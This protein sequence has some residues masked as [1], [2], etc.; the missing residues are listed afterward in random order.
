MSNFY[1]LFK[2]VEDSRLVRTANGALGF[3]T[4]GKA[5]LDMNFGVSSY[6]SKSEDVILKDF[7]RAYSENPEL[8]LKWAFYVG[9]V[10]EGL[11]ERRLFRCLIKL[12]CG[13]GN[14]NN[15][16]QYIGEYNRFDSLMELFDTAAE[17]EMIK[18]VQKQLAEDMQNVKHG[19]NISLLAKWM[20]SVNTS[21]D[22]TK[23]KAYRFI[24]ALGLTPRNY[25]K[26]LSKLRTEI[27]IIEQKMCSGDWGS[28]N[29]EQVP[30]K[31]NLKYKNAFL[32]NDETR[33][34][35]FLS[36]LDKGEVKINSSVCFP[37]D[38]VH[39]Y[40]TYRSTPVDS[41]L[42]GMWKA[43]PNTVDPSKNIL[44]VRDGS[45]SMTSTVDPNSSVRALDISTALAI[46]FAERT[47]D[48]FKNK[49]ITF[50]A[51]PKL[52][53]MSHCKNLREKLNL[54][55]TEADCSNTNLEKTFDMILQIAVSN[56]LKQEEIPSILIV[57]DM[58]FDQVAN[59]NSYWGD[60]VPSINKTLMETMSKRWANAGYKLPKL[61]F[62]NVCSRSGAIPM[63]ENE[64]GVTL[65]SGFSVNTV[66]MIMENELDP[67]K[68][69]EKILMTERY[70][71]IK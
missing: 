59:G 22:E 66:K 57:S 1:D 7:I 23:A 14:H 25:R 35:E 64:L 49:Y 26:M 40:G 8:A 45:G 60:R 32:K 10:R 67:F 58:E 33:R 39:K 61:I 65:V 52:V 34:R 56:N 68:A 13:S 5:L 43:L 17:D 55:Y 20:P 30:S 21:S 18:F 15:L 37:H 44:V 42:E 16:I 24:Q 53:D 36:K 12:I 63:R 71:V 28:I 2:K 11:G 31:A 19:R 50:G 29:Y 48:A 47:N 69:L 54:S 38:I 3:A 41:A 70:S 46:Y 27:Q 4:T 9:D 51:N 6:R 62:W